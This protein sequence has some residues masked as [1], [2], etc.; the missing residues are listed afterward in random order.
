MNASDEE[1][2]ALEER[3]QRLLPAIWDVIDEHRKA[4]PD[5]TDGAIISALTQIIAVCAAKSSLPV[6][7]LE[8]L[9]AAHPELTDEAIV[10]QLMRVPYGP[11]QHRAKE[12]A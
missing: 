11:R 6:A 8:R 3:T 10:A 2:A 9:R 5:L 12:D 7:A 4:D 1:L